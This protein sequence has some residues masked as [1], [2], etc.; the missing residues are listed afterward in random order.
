MKEAI[1]KLREMPVALTGLALG[2]AG[3]SGALSNFLGQFP[4]I[5][6]DLIS[7]FLVTVIFIKNIFHFNVLKEELS[8]PTL[9]SFIPT[10]DMTVMILGGFISSYSLIIGRAIWFLAILAHV[11]F[12]S[13]F[14]YHRIKDFQMHHIVPSWFV[15]PVG[16]VVACVAGANMGVSSFTHLIFYIGFA[17]YLIMLPFMLYRVMFVQPIDESRLPTFAIMAAPPSLCLAG[18]L[19][20][21]NTP[22]EIIIGILLPL[23]VFMTLL[24]YL[25]F[26]RILKI[27]FNPSYASLTFPLAIGSTA[28]SILSGPTTS[29]VN[30]L[31]STLQNPK[32]TPVILSSVIPIAAIQSSFNFISADISML[33]RFELPLGCVCITLTPESLLSCISIIGSCTLLLS[34]IEIS[35]TFPLLSIAIFISLFILLLI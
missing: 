26:F 27:S 17:L 24:V 1:N 5:V 15:P 8:H 31:F 35:V 16:I 25:S 21:F 14:F 6:G 12:C 19:T 23:A 4:V 30:S 2:I 32:V 20:V 22:S 7:L 9:G 13:I 18:Y 11:I 10:L 3:V 29:C 34:P 28:S 33:D